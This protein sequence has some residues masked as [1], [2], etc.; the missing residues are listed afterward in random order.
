M[1]ASTKPILLVEDCENDE[2]H[3]LRAIWQAGLANPVVM[4]RSGEEAVSYLQRIQSTVNFDRRLIPGIMMLDL[5]L[6]GMDGFAVLEWIQ[7]QDALQH[8]FV[9]ALT[10]SSEPDLWQRAY[11]L[12]ADVFLRKPIRADELGYVVE[13]HRHVWATA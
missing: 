7:T 10:D 5:K 4:V 8:M 12:G 13:T 6:P 11:K 2:S 1:R 3:F 9:V